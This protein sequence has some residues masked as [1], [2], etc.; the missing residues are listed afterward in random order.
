MRTLLCTMA[1]RG[2]GTARLALALA[3]IGIPGGH[4]LFGCG[5]CGSMRT[6][7]SYV[8]ACLQNFP[9]FPI[10][11]DIP[12]NNVT[13]NVVAC[14][15]FRWNQIRFS[16]TALDQVPADIVYVFRNALE[17]FLD[18]GVG[19]LY[20][21]G[22]TIGDWYSLVNLCGYT[23]RVV[24]LCKDGR[25]WVQKLMFYGCMSPASS[26]LGS[27]QDIDHIHPFP[28]DSQKGKSPFELLCLHWSGLHKWYLDYD[29]LRVPVEHFNCEAMQLRILDA[30][31]PEAAEE[32]RIIF[33][34]TLT[35]ADGSLYYENGYKMADAYSKSRGP[36]TG[37]PRYYDWDDWH[38]ETFTSICGGVMERLGYSMSWDAAPDELVSVGAI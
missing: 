16:V 22:Y 24:H 36:Y 35:D 10:G 27:M 14:S 30:L 17:T 7:P 15:F 23:H 1:S 33:C 9:A 31:Y 4:E 11:E 8:N 28:L 25:E 32:Q 37:F 5:P 29:A 13:D 19:F 34:N 6:I 12:C 20:D 21:S 3:R 2:H 18:T 26:H 38:K